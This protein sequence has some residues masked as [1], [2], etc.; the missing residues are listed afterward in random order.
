MLRVTLTLVPGGNEHAA[1][2]LG[3]IEIANVDE[4]DRAPTAA[5]AV[6]ARG[7]THADA[8]LRSEPRERGWGIVRSAI[9]ALLL[10]IVM[11]LAACGGPDE[12]EPDC[13]DGGTVNI[14]VPQPHGGTKWVPVCA[15][16]NGKWR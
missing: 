7:V 2:E 4:D 13:G 3:R 12:S 9:S 5:Y 1:R 15:T 6:T 14:P 8:T 16:Q 10:L 11:A